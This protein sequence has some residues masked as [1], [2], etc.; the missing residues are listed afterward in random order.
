MTPDPIT[1]TAGLNQNC[2]LFCGED[3]VIKVEMTGYD[4]TTATGLNWWLARSPYAIETMLAK[5]LNSGIEVNGTAIEITI[6]STDT[7]MIIPEIYYHEL[8]VVLADGSLKIAMTGNI[9]LR[10]SLKP[11]VIP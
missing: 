10:M 1:L 8:R 3:K 11:E 9:I 2:Q 7:E 4:L 6:D 5:F